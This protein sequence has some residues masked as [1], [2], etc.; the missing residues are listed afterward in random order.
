LY[1]NIRCSFT[2]EK[3]NLV[4]FKLNMAGYLRVLLPPSLVYLCSKMDK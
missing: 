3:N 4:N 2:S 1:S